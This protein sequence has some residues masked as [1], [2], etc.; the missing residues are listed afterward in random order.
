MFFFGFDVELRVRVFSRR[1]IASCAPSGER[2]MP[3][4]QRKTSLPVQITSGSPHVSP[5][6]LEKI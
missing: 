3:G 1:R 6:S 4:S 2:I 5:P